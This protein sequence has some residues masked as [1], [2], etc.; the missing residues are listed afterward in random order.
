M[1]DIIHRAPLRQQPRLANRVASPGTGIPA[2][3]GI[4]T[5]RLLPAVV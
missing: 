3:T 4:S 1:A 5:S 2:A